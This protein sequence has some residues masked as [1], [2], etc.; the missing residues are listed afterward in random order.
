MQNKKDVRFFPIFLGATIGVLLEIIATLVDEIVVGTL[1]T[2]EAFASVN[3]IEPYT[4]F[5]V[6][7]AYLLTVAAAALIVRA[8]GAG[9]QK[10]MSEIFSQTIIVCGIVGAFLTLIYVLFTP[11]LVKFVAD[12]PAVYDNALAYF[13]AIRFYPLV[14][15]FDTFMFTYVLYRGG[16]VHFY[17]AIVA[18]IGSNV[19]LS[20]YLGSQMGLAGI[21]LAS[22]LSLVIALAIKL[23]FLL[24]KKHG[25]TFRWYFNA[26]EA[27]EIAKLGFPESAIYMFVVLM[28]MAINRFTL[29]QYGAA[30][31]A[32]VAVVINLFETAF[33]LSEGIGEYEIVAVNDSI[34]KNSNQSM[35]RAI[36]TTLRA[37]LIDGAAIFGLI[38]LGAGVLPGAFDIDNE[39]TFRLASV[40]LRILSP[41]AL[42]I[43]LTRMTATFYQYTRRI[44]RT[45]LLFGMAIALFPSLFGMLLGRI[46]IEWIAVGIAIGPLVAFALMYGFVRLIKKE[47]LFD[48]ALMHLD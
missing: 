44:T 15:I 31:V 20:W 16:Y 39:E 36:K 17:T 8:H 26:R 12:D 10:K 30:G 24:S 23:T 28:E 11:Q 46:S 29:S 35:Y 33:Y 47:K 41:T 40:M 21:G 43:C 37:A 38:L 14:D 2:D 6:F 45:L 9:N 27:L 5:E 18:R 42:F 32:A 4:F 3:L 13:K 19:L 1:F 48:Y 7:I 34:G 25:L 22:I